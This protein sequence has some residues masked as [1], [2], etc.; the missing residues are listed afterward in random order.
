MPADAAYFHAQFRRVNPA[1]DQDVYTIL[2]GVK[3][4]GQYVGTYLAWGS[5]VRAGGARAR[6]SSSSTATASFPTICGTGTEDYF[7]GSYDFEN[8]ETP[9]LPDLHHALHGAGPGLAAGRSLRPGQR[10]GLYRWHIADPVRF[11]KDL[12]VTI[13]A[14]GWQS[15]GR[16]L[17]LE[18]DIASVAY[19]YQREPHAKFP[20]L[21]DGAG[22]AVKPSTV[23]SSPKA[24][25]SNHAIM[26]V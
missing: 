9:P 23:A 17:P 8:Q 19:W 20:P 22:L 6:S 2:D 10:F 18:D 14:L 3:G 21:P 15:G 16:Y 13:Q 11:E 12:K 4:K 25:E 24:V 7:C 26:A 1:A 5:T